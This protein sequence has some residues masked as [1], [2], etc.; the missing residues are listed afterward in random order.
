MDISEGNKYTALATY[1][2][3]RHPANRIEQSRGG[4]LALQPGPSSG[5]INF[6]VYPPLELAVNL[7]SQKLLFRLPAKWRIIKIDYCLIIKNESPEKGE[8]LSS[9]D[10]IRN[11]F[12]ENSCGSIDFCTN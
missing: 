1:Y 8:P 11:D 7:F 4:D 5:P 9:G 10:C 12:H 2:F 6:L 3:G